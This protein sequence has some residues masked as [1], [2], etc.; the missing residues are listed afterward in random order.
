MTPLD[1]AA[2]KL[3]RRGSGPPLV[4]LHCL[5][6]DHGIWDI[7]AAGLERSFSVLSL[8]FPGHGATAV[9]A[10]G[11]GMAELAA[12]LK[13]VLDR[14]GVGRAH[15]GGISLGGLV[16]QQFAAAYPDRVDHLILMDTTARYTDDA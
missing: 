8:D 7:A 9:P 11:Y 12:M 1:P 4:L 16:A 13:S 2:V 10:G 5:G 15:V 6:V 14:E 3:H